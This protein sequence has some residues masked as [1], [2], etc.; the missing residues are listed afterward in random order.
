MCIPPSGN[1]SQAEENIAST[2]ADL[3]SAKPDAAIVILGDFN[4]ASLKAVLPR[5]KQF[6]MC[7]TRE[8][9]TLDLCYCYLAGAYIAKQLEP[10]GNSDHNMVLLRPTYK[11]KFKAV[12]PTL[13]TVK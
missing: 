6:V 9:N 8:Q 3:E 5:Y 1:K 10:L 2:V 12:E 11:Q 4:G 7:A 13:K